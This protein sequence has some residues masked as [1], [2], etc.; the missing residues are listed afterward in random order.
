MI[1]GKSMDKAIRF[2]VALNHKV[3][4]EKAPRIHFCHKAQ[5]KIDALVSTCNIEVGWHL[6]I[7]K[8]HG[9][10]R[11]KDVLVYPQLATAVTV[12]GD[13]DRYPMWLANLSDEE[14]HM[15][16]G[17][18]HSHVNMGV[19]PSGTDWDYYNKMLTV[20][21]DYYL[22][23][24]VNKQGDSNFLLYDI[25][26]NSLYYKEDM[27]ITSDADMWA[28]DQLATKVKRFERS[29]ANGSQEKLHVLPTGQGY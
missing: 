21:K 11:V 13:D 12:E 27:I 5:S 23:M 20:A 19:G 2:D 3:A 10:Y 15:L 9:V 14:F 17:Q 29:K 16:K 28:E 26:D 8:E 25:K 1:S 7:S 4:P 6:L 18:G 24:I 22:F